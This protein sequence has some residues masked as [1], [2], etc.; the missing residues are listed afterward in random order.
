M[1][2]RAGAHLSDDEESDAALHV[3]AA[4]GSLN[5]VK[6]LAEKGARVDGKTEGGKSALHCA[7]GA[8][9]ESVELV[10]F[11]LDNELQPSDADDMG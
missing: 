10:Q 3:A 8:S 6:Y 11:L 1:A 5:I 9:E 4:F 2:G 7:A